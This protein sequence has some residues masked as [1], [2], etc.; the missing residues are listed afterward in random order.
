VF[1][2]LTAYHLPASA[3]PDPATLEAQLAALPFKPCGPVEPIS[4]GFVPP[5]GKDH[6]ALAEW[7]NGHLLL[8]LQFEQRLLPGSVVRERV[9][10]KAKALEQE[11]GRKPGA[12]RRRELKDEVLIDLLPQAFTRQSSLRVWIAPKLE[13]L[14]IDATAT[15]RLDAALTALV[16]AVPGLAPQP[17][18]TAES[19]ATCM[20]A[21]LLDGVAPAGFGI[22]REA[23]LRSTDVQ[24][25]TVRYTRHGLDGED[26]QQHLAAGKEVRKLALNWK[27]RLDLVLGENLQLSKLKL[28]DGVFENDGA[29]HS[30]Q[31]PF[32][33]DALLLTSE[34][35]EL[36]PAL[37]EGLGG[38]VDG[39]GAP[40]PEANKPKVDAAQALAI[41]GALEAD[42][43]PPW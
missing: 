21:W 18:Q 39:L 29:E 17:L 42:D 26:V 5:R 10:E 41:A 20:K 3:Q 8:R 40:P 16:K 32:D 28:D 34:L 7:V 30:E 37:F 15:A 22:G 11:S 31:D 38:R 23:E 27:D 13:L 6:A 1:K 2:S 33:G 19:P 36:L 24:A 43:A 4:F 9:E 12:K 35:S 14:V 25:A